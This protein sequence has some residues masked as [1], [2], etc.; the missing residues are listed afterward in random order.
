MK[1]LKVL[2]RLELINLLEIN[3]IRHGKDPA[4]RRRKGILLGTFL[5]LFVV[6]AGYVTAQAVGIAALGQAKAIP[7]LYFAVSFIF[8]LLFGIYTA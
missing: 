4:A 8:T 7:M 6:L 1:T 2:A 5:F 3:E